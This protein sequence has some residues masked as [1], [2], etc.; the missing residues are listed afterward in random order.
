M[1]RS[2][3]SDADS[4]SPGTLLDS[5]HSLPTTNPNYTVL[6]RIRQEHPHLPIVIS[7]GKQWP[8]TAPIRDALDLHPFF[9]CH[10]NGSVIYAPGG[11]I[12]Y[13]R[14]LD[15][16]TV[17]SVYDRLKYEGISLFLHDNNRVY[18]VLPFKTGD[19]DYWTSKLRVYG[20]N[21]LDLTGADEIMEKVK[22]GDISVVK[23]EICELEDAIP[24]LIRLLS[25]IP[26]F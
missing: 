2:F 8:S 21:V 20:Q 24:G 25:N 11:E 10:L 5:H 18:Q 12:L 13:R 4:N 23:M 6:R 3:S 26:L 9:A 16:A 19:N 17:L 7:T 14:G 22:S 15:S 1:V